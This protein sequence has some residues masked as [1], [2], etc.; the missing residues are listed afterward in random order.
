MRIK[1]YIVVYASLEDCFNSHIFKEVGMGQN[2]KAPDF[3]DAQECF[4]SA[5]ATGQLSE[6]KAADNFAGLYMYMGTWNGV[7]AFKNVET[8]EYL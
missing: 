5:I 3:L 6:D 1:P 2:R 7:D 8:R 4:A